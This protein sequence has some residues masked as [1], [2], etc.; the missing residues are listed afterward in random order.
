[1]H[2]VSHLCNEHVPK[3]WKN[4]TNRNGCQTVFFHNLWLLFFKN[5]VIKKTRKETR[6]DCIFSS[7]S[8][9]SLPTICKLQELLR[10]IIL[11]P[12]F[13][14]T[15]LVQCYIVFVDIEIT[16]SLKCFS[17]NVG[18]HHPMTLQSQQTLVLANSHS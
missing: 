9:E 2:E 8:M 16:K 7:S 3:Y 1:M 13:C 4:S 15:W 14:H 12:T 10:S 18:V 17:S 11:G 5:Q 6:C